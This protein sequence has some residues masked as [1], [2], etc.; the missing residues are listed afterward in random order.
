MDIYSPHQS[1]GEIEQE[2][3]TLQSTLTELV[4]D[5]EGLD[6]TDVPPA[7]QLQARFTAYAS[8]V[9]GCIAECQKLTSTFRDTASTT[10]AEA[11]D[12]IR[13]EATSGALEREQHIKKLYSDLHS[14]RQTVAML[15][16]EVAQLEVQATVSSN[17]QTR[18]Q[19]AISSRDQEI[20]HYRSEVF[21]LRESTARQNT[22]EFTL[23]EHVERLKSKLMT[24]CEKNEQMEAHLDQIGILTQQTEQASR[25]LWAVVMKDLWK[26]R[27]GEVPLGTIIPWATL[28]PPPEH[29]VDRAFPR[30]LT[31]VPGPGFQW[32]LSICSLAEMDRYRNT[33]FSQL[34]A[35]LTLVL[36]LD[37]IHSSA[38]PILEA[39][40]HN[41]RNSVLEDLLALETL[42]MAVWDTSTYVRSEDRD[43]CECRLVEVI[44]RCAHR[45]ERY[46]A[47]LESVTQH[48]DAVSVSQRSVVVSAYRMWAR[49]IEHSRGYRS[50][51]VTPLPRCLSILQSLH[52][53]AEV[54]RRIH[55]VAALEY[56][57]GGDRSKPRTLLAGDLFLNI[58]AY[59]VYDLSKQEAILF[60]PEEAHYSADSQ[61]LTL[62]ERFGHHHITV[63]VTNPGY[64]TYMDGT[65]QVPKPFKL[66]QA[67]F[68]ARNMVE[69]FDAS[70]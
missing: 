44:L 50:A 62:P 20:E 40:L 10:L 61:T 54:R 60:R 34:V 48:W 41:I 16:L 6:V 56:L 21:R 69:L 31:P 9:R 19:S 8:K 29:S 47:R 42:L 58:R 70:L 25:N 24:A 53:F 35:R 52:E 2:I 51:E 39:M 22:T 66:N 32:T 33:N 12:K 68:A 65:F 43:I 23:T 15:R 5:M 18:L 26:H 7:K 14:E 27:F 13:Q 38:L 17:E 67:L 64:S 49:D 3:A 36:P 46:W 1:P 37:Y 30:R 28:R 55:G 4:E 63:D 57:V 45:H 11:T 59:F